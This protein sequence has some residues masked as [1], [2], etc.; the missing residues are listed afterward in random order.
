[1]ATVISKEAEKTSST[2][3]TE[4]QQAK[5]FQHRNSISSQPNRVNF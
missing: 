1:M 3:N 5:Y 4:I 2:G